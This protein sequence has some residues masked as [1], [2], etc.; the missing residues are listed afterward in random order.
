MKIALAQFEVVRGDLSANLTQI[1][2][3]AA[4]AKDQNAQVL[5]L[6]EMCTCLL[7]TSPSPRDA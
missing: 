2:A 5:F 7:Y 3:F 6:P 1:Q 4:K